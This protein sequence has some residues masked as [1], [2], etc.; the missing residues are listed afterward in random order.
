MESLCCTGVWWLPNHPRNAIHGQLEFHPFQGAQLKTFGSFGALAG[1]TATQQDIVLGMSGNGR[2][3]TLVHVSG[4]PTPTTPQET[5]QQIQPWATAM[6]SLR[7][8]LIVM[9]KHLI[10]VEQLQFDRV[11]VFYSHLDRWANMDGFRIVQKHNQN[12]ECQSCTVS[13]K[14]PK[15]ICCKLNDYHVSFGFCLQTSSSLNHVHLQQNM[16]VQLQHDQAAAWQQIQDK[17]L[18]LQNLLSFGANMPIQPQSIQAFMPHCDQ[19][20]QLLYRLR[21]FP[22][23]NQVQIDAAP[24]FTLKDIAKQLDVHLKQW[25]AKATVLQPVHMLYFSLV[26]GPTLYAQNKFLHLVQ[27]L[28]TY[29]SRTHKGQASLRKRLSEV[30]HHLKDVFVLKSGQEESFITQVVR[31][32]NYLTHYSKNHEKKRPDWQQLHQLTQQ[33]RDMVRAVLLLE[34]GFSKLAVK[35]MLTRT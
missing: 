27:A 23:V 24:L 30:L 10:H 5:S 31:T 32:R 13:Y 22:T 26:F 9:G 28:E 19:T 33:L 12:K 34:A 11:R 14:L 7:A 29:H 8:Q 6:W 3:I 4:V 17:L 18:Q 2:L 1:Q 35:N 15:P 16:F 20:V 25:F 21:G